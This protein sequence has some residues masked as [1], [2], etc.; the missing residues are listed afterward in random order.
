MPEIHSNKAER[1]QF[2]SQLKASWEAGTSH[3]GEEWIR[4]NDRLKI[5][6]DELNAYV[7]ALHRQ[8]PNG[9]TIFTAMG[10]F[11]RGKDNYAPELSWGDTIR[12][13]R[14]SYQ[15]L[16]ALIAELA[17]TF[18]A[19]KPV[20]SLRYIN[21]ADWSASWESRF[22]AQSDK[23]AKVAS[24]LQPSLQSFTSLLG[25]GSKADCSLSRI[26][27]TCRYGRGAPVGFKWK[28]RCC[29]RTPV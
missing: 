2:V 8:S 3:T 1:K 9:L 7:E 20:P 16:M 5:R 18:R 23:L 26:E 28:L 12:H 17:L 21:I 24:T 22:L 11:V 4:V 25:I 13:D 15:R 14:A 29:F 27:R 10:V 19:I 6:R